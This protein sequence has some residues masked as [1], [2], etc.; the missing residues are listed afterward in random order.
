MNTKLIFLGVVVLYLVLSYI[1]SYIYHWA[2]LL[3]GIITLCMHERG[4]IDRKT[5]VIVYTCVAGAYVALVL[6]KGYNYISVLLIL[7]GAIYFYYSY[8]IRN[9]KK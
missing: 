4:R 2:V 1:S 8:F 6:L 5:Y 9:K 3:T 7:I